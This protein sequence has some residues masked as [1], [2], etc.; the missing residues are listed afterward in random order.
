MAVIVP[1]WDNEIELSAAGK[2]LIAGVDEAGRGAWAGPLVAAAVQGLAFSA[3]QD[4]V[5]G[6]DTAPDQAIA[7]M[8]RLVD[9]LEARRSR[10]TR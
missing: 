4:Q 3:V 5:A 10:R 7:A 1:S 8:D 6:Y 9:R 2:R